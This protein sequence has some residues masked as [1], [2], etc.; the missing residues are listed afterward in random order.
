M[1]EPILLSTLEDN[2]LTL[3]LNRPDR[4]NALNPGLMRELS[5]ALQDAADDARVGCVLLCGNGRSFCAGG[6]IGAAR[7]ANAQREQSPE[8][9]AADA[10]RKA[11]RG[12]TTPEVMISW[13]RRSAESA[14]LLH[15][16]PKP[17]IAAVHGPVVGAG[18]NLAAACDFRIAAEDVTFSS[19]FRKV[20]YSGDFGGSYFLT[21]L[22]G[23]AKARE[24]YLLDKRLDAQE[25]LRLGFITQ[26]A[27]QE[28]LHSDALAV[29]LKLAHG[30]RIAHRYIKKNLNIAE[31][32]SLETVLDI[33][34][35][36]QFRCSQTEDHKE[37]VKALFEKRAPEFRGV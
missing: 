6:D 22:L 32:G 29:A 17:T 35:T 5:K 34:A 23:T 33:E 20:G 27:E 18:L 8:E 37:A 1:S 15:Q 30:P 9:L 3:T 25:A 11:K 28:K 4:L 16:M 21:R 24:L 13:L 26:V 7:D 36:H 12:P 2:V 31:E 19:G 14:R 10:E